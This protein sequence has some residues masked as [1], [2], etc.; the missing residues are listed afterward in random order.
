MTASEKCSVKQVPARVDS[1]P[2]KNAMRVSIIVPAYNAAATITDT[3]NS[4]LAQTHKCWEAIVIDDGS[5][6]KTA[7]I[8]KDLQSVTRGF[9]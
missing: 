6:D 1:A 4:I 8:V 2:S 7:V 9:E 3:L 5:T